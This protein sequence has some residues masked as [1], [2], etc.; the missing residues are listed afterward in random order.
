MPLQVLRRCG[1]D[2]ETWPC[3]TITLLNDLA[4]VESMARQQARRWQASDSLTSGVTAVASRN[5]ATADQP[6]ASRLAG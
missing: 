2:G 4:A 3:D 6:M 5:A 1:R